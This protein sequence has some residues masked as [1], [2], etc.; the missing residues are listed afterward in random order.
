VRF[1]QGISKELAERAQAR[2]QGMYHIVPR[3][4]TERAGIQLGT[5]MRIVEFNLPDGL[6]VQHPWLGATA[7]RL[8]LKSFRVPLQVDDE[9]N[10]L[11]T[12]I[13]G[14]VGRIQP[15]PVHAIETMTL[16]QK[17]HR[18]IQ[19]DTGISLMNSSPYRT[20]ERVERAWQA[21]KGIGG[22]AMEQSQSVNMSFGTSLSML[23]PSEIFLPREH[24]KL[25]LPYS[26]K[27][28]AYLRSYAYIQRMD[29]G[30]GQRQSRL[31]GAEVVEAQMQND[32]DGDRKIVLQTRL[33][34]AMDR[35]YAKWY[36]IPEYPGTLLTGARPDAG[37]W[38]E[39]K[40][41]GL[42]GVAQDLELLKGVDF[43]GG[44][45]PHRLAQ[46]LW[47][48]YREKLWDSSRQ[49][50]EN[51]VRKSINEM[52]S[53]IGQTTNAMEALQH[54]QGLSMLN[55][56]PSAERQ[57]ILEDRGRLTVF[58]ARAQL[59]KLEGGPQGARQVL[60]TVIQAQ[61]KGRGEM[62][63]ILKGFTLG[64][65]RDIQALYSQKQLL[66]QSTGQ[67]NELIS[68]LMAGGD[69]RE[70][71]YAMRTGM[72][73][74]VDADGARYARP[75]PIARPQA[76]ARVELEGRSPVGF[77]RDTGLFDVRNL[78]K[79]VDQMP[80]AQVIGMRD[81]TTGELL[82]VFNRIEQGA[83]GT[84]LYHGLLMMPV[85]SAE[86]KVSP[87]QAFEQE[88]MADDKFTSSMQVMDPSA[89]GGMRVVGQLKGR[90]D[91]AGLMR[92]DN[93]AVAKVRQLARVLNMTEDS[94]WQVLRSGPAAA[95]QLVQR[96]EF[97]A[98]GGHRWRGV[99]EATQRVATNLRAQE[100]RWSEAEGMPQYPT[101]VQQYA[102]RALLTDSGWLAGS[103]QQVEAHTSLLVQNQLAAPYKMNG[104]GRYAQ[105]IA[106]Q[107]LAEGTNLGRY[108]TAMVQGVNSDWREVN[109]ALVQLDVKAYEDLAWEM[110]KW[111]RDN[112][113]VPIDS[114]AEIRRRVREKFSGSSGES[115]IKGLDLLGQ[116]SG[117]T[118]AQNVQE[119]AAS[120]KRWLSQAELADAAGI[121][122]QVSGTR[123]IASFFTNLN[124]ELRHADGS[125]ERVDNLVPVE[126]QAVRGTLPEV[127]ERL[128]AKRPTTAN[129]RALETMR[130]MVGRTADPSAQ[131]L[132]QLLHMA[133]TVVDE[134]SE[135][136]SQLWATAVGQGEHEPGFSLQLA[137][138]GG[139]LATYRELE[140]QVLNSTEIA[141]AG[142]QRVGAGHAQHWG[143]LH[144]GSVRDVIAEG[145]DQVL[146]AAQQLAKH[147]GLPLAPIHRAGDAGGMDYIKNFGLE[148]TG[149]F[150]ALA[151][152]LMETERHLRAAVGQTTADEAQRIAQRAEANLL[153]GADSALLASGALSRLGAGAEHEVL[154]SVQHI[155][156]S[157]FGHDTRA[158]R[159]LGEL[160]ETIVRQFFR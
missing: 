129:R 139:R 102:S 145:D 47:K 123:K 12:H 23:L 46:K 103:E 10:L 98:E 87:W 81:P 88:L 83:D 130:Q 50:V 121:T 114:E 105:T 33:V 3:E 108:Q 13:L 127:L 21:M 142:L 133:Q 89:P 38:F 9:G 157:V 30:M 66:Q 138:S 122:K 147:S 77:L 69:L 57:W 44:Q 20:G 62:E 55:A 159:V 107:G 109:N 84:D 124:F 116:E 39:R 60:E 110:A 42:R 59:M 85:I 4:Q 160:G 104:T 1:N 58:M 143:L 74:G 35:E 17:L 24:S 120:N 96:Y 43:L 11:S 86:G 95:S 94:V 49:H 54:V 45:N 91:Y 79:R 125:V 154:N 14:L 26:G 131:E 151:P 118:S 19:M 70:G 99:L 56:L 100:I 141:D 15:G 134:S 137:T 36:H 82:P 34:D 61:K 73:K 22:L 7:Q 68:H 144:A 28:P 8:N 80:Q 27:L 72:L 52:G 153:Q 113:G 146:Y 148:S 150:D 2:A 135:P 136:G 37:H 63:S 92:G 78:G 41:Q 71:I 101:G 16:M 149:V 93:E 31:Y 111:A 32:A 156:S 6:F 65:K 128:A 25:F 140:G 40:A 53:A 152:E 112:D 158:A 29:N 126:G 106:R 76:A 155:A 90:W 18:A 75:V 67:F 48:S 115:S 5:N 119:W 117:F 64:F 132:D 97:L 51:A